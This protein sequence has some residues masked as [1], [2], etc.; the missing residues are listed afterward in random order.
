MT[1]LPFASIIVP[2]KNE[3]RYLEA[4]LASLIGQD[5]PRDRYEIIVVDDGSTD[6]SVEIARRFDVTL[7]ESDGPTISAVRNLGARRARG[8]IL[9]FTDADCVVPRHWLREALAVLEP[10]DVGAAG[11]YYT[12]LPP[13]AGWIP[14][15]W[16]LIANKR[17]L[18]DRAAGREGVQELPW[19]PGGDLFV[20]RTCYEQVGGFDEQLM[21][22][23]DWYLGLRIREAGFRIRG[24]PRL[25]V[26]HLKEPATLQHFFR[27]ERWRGMHVLK[28]FRREPR[29]ML[30]LFP[31]ALGLYSLGASAALA[32]A[33]LPPLGAVLAPAAGSM[34]SL[35]YLAWATRAVIETRESPARILPLTLLLYLY[36]LA[37][38]VSAVE[39]LLGEE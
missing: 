12:E 37:R 3:E 19:V 11:Y 8:E 36:G 4:C 31:L 7:L 2:M 30:G 5:Y 20:K 16:N 21:T 25:G 38:G 15:T 6:R 23:E 33:A 35:P 18:I 32:L 22:A 9:A 24:G 14:R 17:D 10:A 27:R 34:L 26:Q 28:L 29:R 39:A 13:G 1:S